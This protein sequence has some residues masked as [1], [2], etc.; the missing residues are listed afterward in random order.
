LFNDAR[1]LNDARDT[2]SLGAAMAPEAWVISTN[3]NMASLVDHRVTPGRHAAHHDQSV[4]QHEPSTGTL[5]MRGHAR[6]GASRMTR[7]VKI[8]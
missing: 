4:P 7:P 3:D 1:D 2:V 6:A 5:Q 8:P